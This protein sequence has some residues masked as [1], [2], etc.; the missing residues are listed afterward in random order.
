MHL[1]CIKLIKS[2]SK[3]T[4]H[5]TKYLKK[6]LFFNYIYINYILDYVKIIYIFK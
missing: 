3:E 2:D 1:T 5:I 4:H 6:M